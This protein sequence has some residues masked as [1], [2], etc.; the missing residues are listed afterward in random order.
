[1]LKQKR[2]KEKLLA[3]IAAKKMKTIQHFFSLSNSYRELEQQ[4]KINNTNWPFKIEYL[5]RIFSAR[6]HHNHLFK[7]QK[8][9]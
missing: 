9:K 5:I 1:M 4:R 6:C 8:S 2:K 3:C 7:D